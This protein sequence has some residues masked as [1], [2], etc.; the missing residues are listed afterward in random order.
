MPFTIDVI[1]FFEAFPIGNNGEHIQT[2]YSEGE[3][4]QKFNLLL[5]IFN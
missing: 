1:S 5:I 3:L 2:K 4:K